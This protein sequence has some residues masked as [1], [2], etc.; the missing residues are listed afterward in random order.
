MTQL[1]LELFVNEHEGRLIVH[2][3]VKGTGVGMSKYGVCSLMSSSF[4]VITRTKNIV[5]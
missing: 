4:V 3:A 2:E 5:R 1:S